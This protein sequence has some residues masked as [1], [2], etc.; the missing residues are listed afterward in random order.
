MLESTTSVESYFR[1]GNSG[2]W[3]VTVSDDNEQVFTTEGTVVSAEN[4]DRDPTEDTLSRANPISSEPAIVFDGDEDRLIPVPNPADEFTEIYVQGDLE[5]VKL[6]VFDAAGKIGLTQN[7]VPNQI[8][9][10][11]GCVQLGSR[12]VSCEG[13]EC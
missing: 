5:L 8:S 11:L 4:F 9:I 12:S 1:D 10:L 13:G 2:Q 3:F 7:I 6:M